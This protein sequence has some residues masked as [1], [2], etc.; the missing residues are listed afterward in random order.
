MRDNQHKP[1]C[2]LYFFLITVEVKNTFFGR[3]NHLWRHFWSALTIASLLLG[4]NHLTRFTFV[5]EFKRLY[6]HFQHCIAFNEASQLPVKIHI[7]GHTLD[8]VRKPETVLLHRA[9]GW[10]RRLEKF[11]KYHKLRT[12]NT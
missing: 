12:F 11:R 9:K 5:G 10:I 2:H 7:S 1:L 4:S 3:T 8:R 6:A